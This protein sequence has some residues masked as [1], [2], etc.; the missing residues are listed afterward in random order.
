MS[1]RIKVEFKCKN[2]NFTPPLLN[3]MHTEP[4]FLFGSKLCYVSTCLKYASQQK[5]DTAYFF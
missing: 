1:I 5:L 2:V 4:N 3:K